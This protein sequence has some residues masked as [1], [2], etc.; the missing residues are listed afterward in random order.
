MNRA[1]KWL[2]VFTGDTLAPERRRQGLAVEPM[3]C[4][5][6]AFRLVT[7]SSGLLQANR[8]RAAGASNL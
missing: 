7:A 2:M 6:N 5:P 1:F 8:S 3:T 4:P